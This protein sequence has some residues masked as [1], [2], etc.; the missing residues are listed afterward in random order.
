[1]PENKVDTVSRLRSP[2]VV[3]CHDA[4]A[5]NLIFAWLRDWAASGLLDSHQFR[6]VLAGPTLDLWHAQV[7]ALPHAEFHAETEVALRG[8]CSLLTGTGWASS[9]EHH[10]RRLA[11]DMNIPSTAVLD[12]WVNYP[13]RFVREAEVVLPDQI[14]VADSYAAEIAGSV[15]RGLPIIELPNTY[16]HDQL[17]AITPKPEENRTL[18]YVLEPLRMDWGRGTPGEL[19]ALDYFAQRLHL[20]LG[21]QATEVL[22]RPHPS[23]PPHKY[24]DW[25]RQH[26]GLGVKIDLCASLSESIGRSRW[27]VG[28]ETFAMV[29]ALAAGRQTY[30]SLPPW[31][32]RCRLP[33][34]EIVHLADLG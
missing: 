14:L 25:A 23:D 11:R 31:A 27:V 22:L 19:Q 8:A 26:S 13:Q 30:S 32:H 12:H 7:S 24:D 15:F 9:L 6:L 2:V 5:A 18:L 16:L 21:T 33:H 10:A 4:G 20:V 34:K 1:M 28:A 17:K 3:V 29:I